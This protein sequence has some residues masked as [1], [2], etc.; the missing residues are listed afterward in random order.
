MIKKE[1]RI[2]I[3]GGTGLEELFSTTVE[4]EVVETK[5]GSTSDGLAFGEIGGAGVVFL[6]R[7][8][9][10]HRF[11]P[12]EIPYGANILAMKKLGVEKIIGISSSGIINAEME[13]GS[14]IIPNDYFICEG[15]SSVHRSPV[16]VHVSLEEAYCPV[17]RGILI[18]KGKR[19]H[20]E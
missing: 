20:G 17:M 5:L 16:V 9:E 11:A 19:G 7:H 8:G 2:G 18:E 13:I 14:I 6:N 3:I 10:G 1:F 15:R 4:H 12:H